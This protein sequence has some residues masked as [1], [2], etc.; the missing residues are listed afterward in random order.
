[1]GNRNI[2][3]A[4]S[5]NGLA[6]KIIQKLGLTLGKMKDEYS[7]PLLCRWFRSASIVLPETFP[8][9]ICG[10]ISV[11]CGKNRRDLMLDYVALTIGTSTNT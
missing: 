4:Q 5:N 9:A 8:Q 3:H 11:N 10:L 1:M 7:N 6:E 2:E